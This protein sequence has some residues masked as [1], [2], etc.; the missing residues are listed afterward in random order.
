MQPP[1]GPALGNQISDLRFDN[2]IAAGLH[3]FYLRQA[4]IN[5]N[6][7]VPFVREAGCGDRP[8]IAKSED[9]NRLTHAILFFPLLTIQNHWLCDTAPLSRTPSPGLHP[10]TLSDKAKSSIFNYIQES[11]S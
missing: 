6:Y 10:R 1:S 4:E 7:V 8:Y 3:G 5:A 2:R 9:A 11:R